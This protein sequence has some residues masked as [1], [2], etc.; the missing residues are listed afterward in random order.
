VKIFVAGGTGVLGRRVAARLV[1]AGHDVLATAR[2]PQKAAVVRKAGATPVEVDIFDT[3]A[4]TTA[5]AGCDAVLRLATKIPPLGAMKVDKAW[6][7]NDRIRR[8]ATRALVE[9]SI[10]SGVG[11][12][13]Q[14]SISFVYAGGGT[15]WIT[16]DHPIDPPSPNLLSALAAEEEAT[17]LPGRGARA[18]TLRFAQ[19]YAADASE[20]LIDMIRRRRFPVVGGGRNF[21]SSLHADD[22]AA[23]VVAALDAPSGIYNVADDEP[24]Q[25]REFVATAAKALGVKPPIRVPRALVGIML[26]GAAT[27]LLRSW[28]ISNARFKEVTGWAP[29]YPSAREG[30]RA[31]AREAPAS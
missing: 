10:A 7:E 24:L 4:L 9:A 23:A 16:E 8:E 17:R 22:A 29:A 6:I 20:E 30:W 26:G 14:E 13:L 21:V 1:E 28:R 3:D 12:Y 5:V 2:S 25:E 31:V 11:V 27:P 18:I 19:F 15:R